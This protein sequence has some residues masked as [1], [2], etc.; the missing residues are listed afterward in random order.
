MQPQVDHR[1]TTT[2]TTAATTP[3]TTGQ[4]QGNHCNHSLKP[5]LN[6]VAKM[7]ETTNIL[8]LQRFC[9]HKLMW[10]QTTIT[11]NHNAAA[12]TGQPQGNHNRAQPQGNH[13][14]RATTTT[15]TTNHRNQKPPQPQTTGQPQPQQP[16]T[17]ATT[18]PRNHKP[19]SNHNHSNH[20]PHNHKPQPLQP[21]RVLR[22][23]ISRAAG[24]A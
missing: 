12:T 11:C 5:Q 18:Q 4:P 3:E 19:Q 1:A 17:T 15:A 14:H 23:V 13:N 2:T 6:V 16:Q 9:N 8:W 24:A 22:R 10:L 20:K 7:L 21:P